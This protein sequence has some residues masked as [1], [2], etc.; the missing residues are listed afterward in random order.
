MKSHLL[1]FLSFLFFVSCRESE[2]ALD[3]LA[4]NTILSK[5]DQIRIEEY[6]STEVPLRDA[7]VLPIRKVYTTN[8][9]SQLE[10][11][12][13]LIDEAP[14]TG[15]CCCPTPT[16]AVEFFTQKKLAASYYVDSFTHKDTAVVYEQGFQYSFLVAKAHWKIFLA[17]LLKK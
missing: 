10:A 8:K 17:G 9:A 12:A 11:F 6:D 16:F 7:A 2:S 5:C 13:G 3:R 15:Y 1:L 14:I 4:F